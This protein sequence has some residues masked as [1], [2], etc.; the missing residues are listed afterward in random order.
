MVASVASAKKC[1]IIIHHLVAF[2]RTILYTKHEQ[3][4]TGKAESL[5]EK[6]TFEQTLGILLVKSEE[7]TGS[8]AD[9]GQSELDPPHFL[10]VAQTI[11]TDELELLVKTCLLEGATGSDANLALD[12]WDSVVH[13]L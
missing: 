6:F 12:Q 11:F 4:S 5:R 7:F 10:L 2:L 1:Q 9:L 13:H 3:L 8:F